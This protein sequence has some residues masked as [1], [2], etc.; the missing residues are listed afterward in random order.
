MLSAYFDESG[1]H[2]GSS[3]CVVAGL[4]A[5]PVRWERLTASWGKVLAS[6]GI[7]DFHAS[8]CVTGGGIFKGWDPQERDRLYIRFVNLVK[9]TAAFRVW[10]AVVMADFH[11]YYDDKG[12][13]IPYRLCALGCA[14]RV[15]QL[16]AKRGPLFVIPYVFDQGPKG[17]WVYAAFDRLLAKGRGSHYY[18]MGAVTRGDRRS[19]LPLQAADLHAYEVYRYFADQWRTERHDA[20]SAFRELLAVPDGGGYLMTGDNMEILNYD[21]HRQDKAGTDEPVGIPVSWLTWE[22]G[23]KLIK[24]PEVHEP[25]G[26][27]RYGQ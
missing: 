26:F 6:A 14:S 5:S 10:T 15:R 22:S 27:N 7:P 12:E 8:D 1:T 2:K 24:P 19:M 18:R 23:I 11:S 17:K 25:P 16:A 21:L 20:R 9:R 13:K 4:M 3:V